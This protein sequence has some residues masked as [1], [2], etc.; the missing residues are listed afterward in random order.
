MLNFPR[1]VTLFVALIVDAGFFGFS[2]VVRANSNLDMGLGLFRSNLSGEL[3]VEL[4]GDGVTGL[5]VIGS[6]DL[7]E[8]IGDDR[9]DNGDVFLWD[10]GDIP[11]SYL[12]N[13]SSDVLGI[14]GSALGDDL[15]VDITWSFLV[16]DNSSLLGDDLGTTSPLGEFFLAVDRFS[17]RGED[18]FVPSS[19]SHLGDDLFITDNLENEFPMIFKTINLYS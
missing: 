17:L 4:D 19:V 11:A 9:R 8:V 16:L 15:H 7:A 18:L 13:L 5:C 10:F 3:Q 14:L 2:F 1:F 12:D 6:K